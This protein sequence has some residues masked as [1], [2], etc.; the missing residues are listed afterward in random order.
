M[1]SNQKKLLM[2]LFRAKNSYP[3][4]G[5]PVITDM[6]KPESGIMELGIAKQDDQDASFN[7]HLTEQTPQEKGSDFGRR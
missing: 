4:L 2:S 1:R 3:R 5:E 7:V 6:G